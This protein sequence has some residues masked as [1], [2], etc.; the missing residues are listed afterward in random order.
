MPFTRHWFIL[1]P[2]RQNVS[3]VFL[4]TNVRET[5]KRG[6]SNLRAHFTLRGCTPGV[7]KMENLLHFGPSMIT[8]VS[9]SIPLAHTLISI[10]GLKCFHNGELFS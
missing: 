7:D 3:R 2:L 9:S 10:R 5:G 4:K 6:R 8:F 1:D